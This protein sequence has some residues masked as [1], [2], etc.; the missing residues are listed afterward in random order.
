MRHN[1]LL[2][3]LAALLLL[4]FACT[5]DSGGDTEPPGPDYAAMR[6]EIEAVEQ[7]EEWT[8]DGLTAPVHVVRTEANVPHVYGASRADVSRV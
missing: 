2:G 6:A 5:D 8:L 1:F 3:A 4:T 7:T